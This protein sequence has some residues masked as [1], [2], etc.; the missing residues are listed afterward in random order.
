MWLNGIAIHKQILLTSLAST[1]ETCRI[2]ALKHIEYRISIKIFSIH[3][4]HL[5]LEFTEQVTIF[6]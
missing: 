1:S 3:L 2:K 5:C 6:G 4:N